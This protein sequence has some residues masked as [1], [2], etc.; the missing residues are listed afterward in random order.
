MGVATTHAGQRDSGLP[1]PRWK[2]SCRGLHGTGVEVAV[3][4]MIPLGEPGHTPLYVGLLSAWGSVDSDLM[5]FPYVGGLLF[6]DSG[7]HT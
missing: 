1:Q 2:V 3:S 4:L 5:L 6:G 7:R